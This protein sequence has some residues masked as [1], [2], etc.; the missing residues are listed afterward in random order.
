MSK[1][2]KVL[3]LFSWVWWLSYWFW[4]AWFQT[5]WAIE[6]DETIA[7]SM[8]KNHPGVKMFV[9]DIRNISPESV[10][11]WIGNIDII[12]WW[13]PCQWFSLKG[14]R[15]WINDERNFLFKEYVKY[16]AYFKPLYFVT[17]Q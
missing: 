17:H 4:M 3:D 5:V 9:G 2:L 13:P 7:D 15:L 1:K 6:F 14:K 16:I 11:E 12:V 10:K 8:L